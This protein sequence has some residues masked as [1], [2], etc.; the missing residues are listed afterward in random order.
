[1]AESGHAL[2]R[3]SQEQ[4]PEGTQKYHCY[5]R[6]DNQPPDQ[7]FVLGPPWYKAR[8]LLLLVHISLYCT[9]C[10]QIQNET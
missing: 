7:H 6:Q 2:I 9:S 1:M 4:P 5:L 8:S 10:N 3:N